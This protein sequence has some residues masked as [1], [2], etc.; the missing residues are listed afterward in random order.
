MKSFKSFK[1]NNVYKTFKDVQ[2]LLALS[3]EEKSNKDYQPKPEKVD[4]NEIDF[5]IRIKDSGIGISEKNIDKLFMNFSRLE[6]HKKMNERGTGLG[7]SICKSLIEIMGG[8][9]SVESKLGEGTSFIV[10]LTTNC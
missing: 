7:L 3:Q 1:V 2:Q 5:E 4:S 6:E 9:V 10:K 8:S